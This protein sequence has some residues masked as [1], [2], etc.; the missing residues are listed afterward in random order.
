MTLWYQFRYGALVKCPGNQQY[1][2]VNH[3]TVCDVIEERAEGFHGMVAHVLKFNNELLAQLVIDNGHRQRAG[4]VCQKLAVVRGLQMQLKIV[5]GLTLLKVQVIGMSE[6]ATLEAA[7]QSFQV[8]S[9]NVEETTG[10][11][12]DFVSRPKNNNVKVTDLKRDRSRPKSS[13][14]NRPTI[15]CSMNN[16]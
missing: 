5:Q 11:H 16:M 15:S 13:P 4:F 8:S 7:A 10:V 6:Y 1:D 12:H 9:V 2:V 14:L 3:V